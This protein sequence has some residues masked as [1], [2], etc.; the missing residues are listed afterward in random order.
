MIDSIF[1]PKGVATRLISY[2]SNPKEG[3]TVADFAAGAGDLLV[4]A[5]KVL[6]NPIII[7][8]DINRTL[9]SEIRLKNTNWITGKCDFL[10]AQSRNKCFA[11]RDKRNAVSLILLNPPFSCRGGKVYNINV[12]GFK[13]KSSKGLAFLL[14]SLNYLADDGEVIAIMPAGSIYS[15]KDSAAWKFI[16]KN[17]YVEILERNESCVFKGKNASTFILRILKRHCPNNEQPDSPMIFSAKYFARI[18]RGSI[19]MNN[20]VYDLSEDSVPLIHTTCI[21]GCELHLNGRVVT[22]RSLIYGPAILLPRICNPVT[23][24]LALGYFDKVAISDCIIA[25]QCDKYAQL[26]RIFKILNNN[27]K[28]ISECYYG[29]GAKYITINRL[30]NMLTSLGIS[31]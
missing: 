29:T 13:T 23:K 4:A 16:K 11:L 5:E 12:N 25:I 26:K 7:A 9:I 30:R 24:K 31:S 28:N 18:K 22:N 10:N 15:E 21:K 17:Y 14:T 8:T 3:I 20:V 6:N 2:F 27:W 19:Q 1:T